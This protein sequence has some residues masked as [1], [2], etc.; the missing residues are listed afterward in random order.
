MPAGRVLH[1]VDGDVRVVDGHA[2]DEREAQAEELARYPERSLPQLVQLEVR[3]D[4]VLVE[5]VLRLADLLRVVAVV[6]GRDL[7]ARAL[8]VRDRLHVRDLFA[9]PRHRRRPDLFQEGDR[10]VGRSRHGVLEPPVGVGLEAEQLRPL[11]PQGQDLGDQPVVVRRSA[12]VPAVH[13]RPPG[14]LAQVAPPGVGEEGLDARAGVEDRPPPFLPAR[15]GGGRRGGAEGVGKADEVPLAFEEEHGVVLVGEQVLAELRE[16]AGEALVDGG[17]ALL[18]HRRQPRPRPDEVGVVEP[19]EALL[20]GGEPPLLPR[21]VDGGD[22]LEEPAVLGDAVPERGELRGHLGLDGL[23]LGGVHRR[24]PDPVHGHHLLEQ[25][26]GP[27]ECGEGV[28]ERG[29]VGLRG[30]PVDGRELGG[31]AGLE[32]GLELLDP[33]LV[34]GRDAP[35]GAGPG[36]EEGVLR[37]GG[38]EE[39]GHGRGGHGNRHVGRLLGGHVWTGFHRGLP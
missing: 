15:L 17:E 3:L 16:Q 8:R 5:V 20:L 30:D 18:G 14:L 19:G 37:R 32:G 12:V 31:H 35:E 10:P 29:G 28:L 26:V 2:R 22:P 24:A 21:L 11:R 9:D 36:C 23:E 27:L 4:C 6:P 34:E 25:P 33:H 7:H 39:R 13:E 38:R 1:L